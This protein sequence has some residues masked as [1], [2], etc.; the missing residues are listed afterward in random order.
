MRLVGLT[1]LSEE[2]ENKLKRRFILG[3]KITRMWVTGSGYMRVD[4]Y[5]KNT[6]AVKSLY[7]YKDSWRVAT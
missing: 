6:N 7:W 3:Y 5:N 1:E 4:L 2:Q